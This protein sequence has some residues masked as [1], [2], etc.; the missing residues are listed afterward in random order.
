MS[1]VGEMELQSQ[2][3]CLFSTGSVSGSLDHGVWVWCCLKAT[4]EL[5]ITIITL[6]YNFVMYIRFDSGISGYR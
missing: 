5:F 6:S 4:E 1:C 3:K 2:L